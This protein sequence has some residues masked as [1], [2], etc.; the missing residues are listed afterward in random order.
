MP[1]KPKSGIREYCVTRSAILETIPLLGNLRFVVAKGVGTVG[2]HRKR[3][4][5]KGAKGQK[6]QGGSW[7][8]TQGIRWEG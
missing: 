8:L 7:G 2:G 5:S 6:G 3:D 4:V 1:S